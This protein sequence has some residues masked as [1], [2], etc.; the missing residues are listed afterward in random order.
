[1]SPHVVVRVITTVSAAVL[2]A[3]PAFSQGR[4][5][6]AAPTT[7]TGTS[8]GSTTGTSTA[9]RTPTTLPST[10][11]SS[12]TTTPDRTTLMLTGR[13]TLEDGTAPPDTATIERVC[14]GS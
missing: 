4:G 13:V 1:M 5:G 10:S 6:T 14:A 3:V 9:S 7:G 12:P 11:P 8:A 2:L